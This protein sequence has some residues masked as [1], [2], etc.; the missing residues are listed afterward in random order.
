MG[1]FM[2]IKYLGTAAAEGIP[3]VFCECE[4]CRKSRKLG[5]RNIRTRSQAIIDNT[6]LIDFPADTYMHYLV[7]N[8]PL[9]KIKTCIITHSHEDHLY[10]EEVPMRKT[11]YSHISSNEPLTFYTCEDG[12]NKLS[13]QITA[14][15]IGETDVKAVK[16]EPYKPFE[17]EGYKILP[18]KA[19][20]DPASNPVVFVIEKDGKSIFYAND[21]SEY[22]DESFECLK[23]LQKPLDVVS[24]D[25]TEA[26]N[27]ST[28]IGHLCLERCIALRNK[29]IDEGI[30][31][32]N[33][34]F[35]LNHFSHN[36]AN[37][38]YD[39][40]VK[41]AAEHDFL[42]SYDGMELEF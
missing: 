20:H 39:E 34:T 31:C 28:Y 37:V 12:Y 24:F 2:K 35:V 25:C 17:A 26:C 13:E 23:S 6:I 1:I 21:S 10:P 40:F 8:I 27:H 41:I 38:I 11:G 30:A 14:Y 19:E 3:A 7:H 5:G 16:I 42:V 4:T 15:N 18:I 9:N 22:N 29:L 33:T 36:G 32:R